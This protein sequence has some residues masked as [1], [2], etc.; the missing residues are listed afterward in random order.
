[1]S[2]AR[3]LVVAAIGAGALY[4]VG[5]VALGSLP[6]VTDSPAHVVAWFREHHDA[7]RLYAW[8]TVFATLGF[9]V[10]AGIIRGTLPAPHRDVFLLGAAAFIVE[11]AV[12]AWY[13]AALALHPASLQPATAGS[14]LDIASFWGRILTGATTMMIAAV[15]VLGLRS[16]AAIPRWLTALGAV[17]FL[18]QAF[19]T[20]TVFGTHGFIA[21]GGAMNV[22]LGAAL[23]A[24]WL[25]GFVAWSAMR[26]SHRSATA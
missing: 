2:Q 13:W 26:L 3:T 20:I 24:L 4:L 18:E 12:Q 5:A 7:A 6:T 15:T 19:E 25:A 8:T 1:M 11:T 10:A 9:A 23:T 14:T 22:V 21:P 16:S 17:A